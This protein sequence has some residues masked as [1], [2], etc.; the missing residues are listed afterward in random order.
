MEAM[1]KRILFPCDYRGGP[2]SLYPGTTL[3][4]RRSHSY[5]FSWT[6]RFDIACKFADDHLRAALLARAARRTLRLNPEAYR[7]I[8]LKTLAPAESVSLIREPENYYDEAEVV[9]DP[10]WLPE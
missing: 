8:V 5:G 10:F 2:T 4:E 3:K 9:V 6:K 7:G 1:T